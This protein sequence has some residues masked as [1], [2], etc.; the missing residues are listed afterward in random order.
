MIKGY[1]P[2]NRGPVPA[3]HQ[4]LCGVE[5]GRPRLIMPLALSHFETADSKMRQPRKAA[6]FDR[7]LRVSLLLAD[8]LSVGVK[9]E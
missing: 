3:L 7:S 2:L 1:E 4:P 9:G 6:P 8:E 5:G